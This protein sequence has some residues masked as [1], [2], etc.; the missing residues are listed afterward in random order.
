MQSIVEFLPPSL[1]SLPAAGYLS[2]TAACQPFGQD[3]NG[4]AAAATVDVDVAVAVSVSGVTTLVSIA[5]I[6]VI[7]V[8]LFSSLRFSS[9][10][11]LVHCSG[12]SAL[13]ALRCCHCCSCCSS[14]CCSWP[15]PTTFA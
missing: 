8:V 4:A 5:P 11:V 9:V 15:R 3:N 12:L 13:A 10:V 2:L 6:D 1:V 7:A 14:C